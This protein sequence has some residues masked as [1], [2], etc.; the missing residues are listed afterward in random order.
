LI[1]AP[2]SIRIRVASHRCYNFVN[3]FDEKS[4]EF[5]YSKSQIIQNC[6]QNIGFWEKRQ[7]FYLK[8]AKIAENCDHNNIGPRWNIFKPKISIRLNFGVS[9]NGRCW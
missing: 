3:I 7:S 2:V 5:F 8:F 6:D 9:C 4:T 1:V